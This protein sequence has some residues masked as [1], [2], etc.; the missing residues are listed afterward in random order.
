MVGGV[1]GFGFSIP[2]SNQRTASSNPR[3]AGN[4]LFGNTWGAGNVLG[5]D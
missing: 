1:H 5:R 3:P 2:P 4:R